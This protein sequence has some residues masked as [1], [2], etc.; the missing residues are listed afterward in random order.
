MLEQQ[1]SENICGIQN[2]IGKSTH[3]SETYQAATER[4][5]SSRIVRIKAAMHGVTPPAPT[6]QA[7]QKDTMPD[8]G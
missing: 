1:H 5:P 3:A 4:T 8:Y 6:K 7:P 2:G